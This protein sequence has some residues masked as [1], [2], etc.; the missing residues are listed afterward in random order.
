MV[1]KKSNADKCRRRILA[2]LEMMIAV[3]VVGFILFIVVSFALGW[4]FIRKQS[5]Y[6]TQQAMKMVE[7]EIL[8]AKKQLVA[9]NKKMIAGIPDSSGESFSY[10]SAPIDSKTIRSMEEI[11]KSFVVWGKLTSDI[12]T[13]IDR[14]GAQG[15]AAMNTVKQE[16]IIKGYKA[17]IHKAFKQAQ[18]LEHQVQFDAAYLD[19]TLVNEMERYAKKC[20]N[21]SQYLM[22]AI[23][24]SADQV[25]MKAAREN[26]K[27]YSSMDRCA[28][29]L[30]N[31]QNMEYKSFV[32]TQLA[33]KVRELRAIS[34]AEEE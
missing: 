26:L 3:N 5:K 34:L 19:G 32:K 27:V 4:W 2:T 13:K 17:E 30:I 6:V 7:Q 12:A 16:E 9:M 8:K 28:K 18:Q 31:F 15:L 10:S 29:D 1:L 23:K 14:Q 24:A 22:D 20:I 11:Y 25:K 33:E 21:Q